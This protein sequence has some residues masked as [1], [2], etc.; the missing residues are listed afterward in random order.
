[1]IAAGVASTTGADPREEMNAAA[2]KMETVGERANALAMEGKLAEAN[3]LYLNLFPENTRTAAQAFMLGNVLFKF[4]PKQSYALHRRA[5]TEMPDDDGAQ[6][7]WALE[8]HRAGEWAGAAESY[9]KYAKAAPDFAPTYGLWAEC[10]I[11]TGKIKEAAETWAKSENAPSGKIETL[12]SLVCEVHTPV[13]SA[14]KRAALLERLRAAAD[15]DAAERLVALDCDF[16]RDWWNGGVHAPYLQRDLALIRSLKFPDAKRAAEA[17]C[18]GE[19]A[20]ALEQ[21]GDAATILRDGGLMPDDAAT[22]PKSGVL[23][24]IVLESVLDSKAM[25]KDAAREKWGNA[26]LE[27]AK[28]EK[29]E[30]FF[31]AA[32]HLF[33]DTPEQENVDRAGWEATGNARFA[34]AVVTHMFSTGK[35]TLDNPILVRAVKEFPE[36]CFIAEVVVALTKRAGRPMTDVLVQGIKAEYTHF[37][38]GGMLGRPKASKLRTYFSALLDEVQKQ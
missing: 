27:R 24:P 29:D 18:A 12:E 2:E 16:E 25:S 31:R 14:V 26:I 38:I 6:Y 22:L 17:L 3:A 1:L 8:Q 34:A 33:Q 5:A 35:L 37:S 10:L 7:E 11:R 15:L 13:T 32:A 20:L 30:G 28:A 4:D 36:N 23:M 19:A 9:A 21:K